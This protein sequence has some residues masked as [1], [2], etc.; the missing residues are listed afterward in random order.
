M[1][2]DVEYSASA[3]RAM[4]P[5]LCSPSSREIVADTIAVYSNVSPVAIA[6]Y[7]E[8]TPMASTGSKDLPKSYPVTGNS[9]PIPHYL[10]AHQH[11]QPILSLD[12]KKRSV[13]RR[14]E[15]EKREPFAQIALCHDCP[16]ISFLHPNAVYHLPR[17]NLPADKHIHTVHS[18]IAY[19]SYISL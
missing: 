9:L 19:F 6:T 13:F 10:A 3:W 17:S 18:R 7:L 14:E 15:V 1:F 2:I 12:S 4:K 5:R 11:H 16:C 8:P